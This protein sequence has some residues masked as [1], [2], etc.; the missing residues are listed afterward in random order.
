M[1][2][3]E[4]EWTW[5]HSGQAQ[6]DPESIVLPGRKNKSVPFFFFFLNRG[7]KQDTISDQSFRH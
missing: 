2:N 6:R 3:D 5:R 7:T 1:Q 4:N